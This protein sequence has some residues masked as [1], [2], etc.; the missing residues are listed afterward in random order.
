M[1]SGQAPKSSRSE[2]T[3]PPPASTEPA[4]SR[5]AQSTGSIKEFQYTTSG[6]WSRTRRS[7][8]RPTLQV[9]LLDEYGEIVANARALIDSG[10]DYTVFSHEWAD[11]LGIDLINDCLPVDQKTAAGDPC[12]HFMYTRGLHVEVADERYTIP[13]VMFCMGLPIAILGRYNFFERYLVMIDEPRRRFFLE[14]QPEDH[15]DD[16]DQLDHALVGD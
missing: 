13:L 7:I 4:L 1:E 11:L 15:P 14:R 3:Q 5:A 16:D 6:D 10:S 12:V 2:R 8:W 9:R